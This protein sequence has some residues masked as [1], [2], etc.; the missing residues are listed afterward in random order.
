MKLAALRRRNRRYLQLAGSCQMLLVEGGQKRTG[1][2]GR[3]RLTDWQQLLNI[4]PL[5]CIVVSPATT[6]AG[7]PASRCFPT[8]GWRGFASLPPLHHRKSSSQSGAPHLAMPCARP[9]IQK[10]IAETSGE[11][12]AA[13]HDKGKQQAISVKRGIVKRAVGFGKGWLFTLFLW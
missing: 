3:R 4:I 12:S 10:I 9:Q 7:R 6:S 11:R 2:N 5:C 13:A 8:A 1:E